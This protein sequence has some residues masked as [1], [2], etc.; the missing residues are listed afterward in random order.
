MAIVRRSLSAF[1]GAEAAPRK[2][3]AARHWG[4]IPRRPGLAG[5]CWP[6]FAEGGLNIADEA[7]PSTLD[8]RFSYHGIAK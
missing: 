5:P 7:S 3:Q 6:A 2:K 1:D 8:A 4:R